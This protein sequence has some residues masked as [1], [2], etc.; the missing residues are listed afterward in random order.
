[1]QKEYDEE[2]V[3]I[4]Q[5]Y[6]TEDTDEIFSKMAGEEM[7][8]DFKKSVKK[9]LIADIME[10]LDDIEPVTEEEREDW[11]EVYDRLYAIKDD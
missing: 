6:G 5:E 10:W 1:M 4:F 8:R 3:K 2:L 9:T 11:G 7:G